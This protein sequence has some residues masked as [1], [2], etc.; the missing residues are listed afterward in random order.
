MCCYFQK[1]KTYFPWKKIK[2]IESALGGM[3]NEWRLGYVEAASFWDG[4]SDSF[5]LNSLVRV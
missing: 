2:S 5:N 1:K 3:A 4:K